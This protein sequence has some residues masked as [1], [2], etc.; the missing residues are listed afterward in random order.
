MKIVVSEKF[1]KSIPQEKKSIVKSKLIKFTEELKEKNFQ[2]K[3]ISNGFSVWKVRG[4]NNI[5]KFRIDKSNRIL[6]TFTSKIKW[7]IDEYEDDENLLILDYCSHDEQIHRS[8]NIKL[9]VGYIDLENTDYTDQEKE[10]FYDEIDNIYENYYYDQSSSIVSIYDDTELEKIFGYN[11]K[12][13][14]YK[15][16]KEQTEI[17]KTQ[18]PLFLFGSAGS[19][20]TTVGI[21][22]IHSI[23]NLENKK[24]AYFTYSNMLKADTKN[25]FDFLCEKSKKYNV[26]SEIEFYDITTYLQHITNNKKVINYIGFKKWLDDKNILTH[27]KSN[28]DP[29]I[30]YR[31]IR[32]IIKGFIDINWE[33]EK[34]NKI[35]DKE[36]Y[37]NLPNKISTFNDK[38][39]AYN[40]AL[41]YQSWLDENN[42]VDDNDLSFY[43]IELIKN[44]KLKKYDFLV[45]DEIQDLTEKQIYFLYKLVKNPINV[46]FSGDFNQTINATYFNTNRIKSLFKLHNKDI[47]FSEKV[48]TTNF[49]CDQEIVKLANKITSLRIEK[50]YKNKN[51]YYE[52]FINLGFED[53]IKPIFLKRTNFNKENLLKTADKRHYVAIVVCDEFEKEK[54]KYELNIKNNVFTVSE[55]K[56]IEVPYVVCYNIISKYNDK[57]NDILKEVDF[58]KHHLYR[59]YF[60]LFYVAITRARKNLCFYEEKD[61]KLYDYL[62]DFIDYIDKFDENTLNLNIESDKKDY[63]KA[64]LDYEANGLY[65]QA[66]NQYKRCDINVANNNIIR[67]N[68]LIIKNEGN[69]LKA[70][71][72]LFDIKEFTLSLECYIACNSDIGIIKNLL[73]LKDSYEDILDECNNLNIDI[74][75]ILFNKINDNK[76]LNKFY[77]VYNKYLEKKLIQHSFNIN[78]LKTLIKD[79]HIPI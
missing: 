25:I 46:I 44:N 4:T 29:F 26:S 52:S 50:L 17:L 3:N 18:M 6:F 68:A 23:Y 58:D 70:G 49:R 77:D 11:S 76:I 56:G 45:I 22:K 42:F 10:V 41:R 9:N 65:K 43:A 66:I 31:E 39:L 19:G 47:K 8:K 78:N 64:G 60:N 71:D 16:N 30:I 21:R 61:C 38:N 1:K 40:I 48:L 59:Y 72:I 12:E 74:L 5:Y 34:L 13:I 55:I 27:L 69:Y 32:G 15:L 54:L 7:T 73:F 63:L 35:L 79:I 14:I 24:I 67:C 2:L 51:D 62:F 36:V 75:D 53:N 20:K 57:W 37:F 33:I 28:I